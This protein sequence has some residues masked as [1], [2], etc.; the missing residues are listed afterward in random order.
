VCS[1]VALLVLWAI[2]AKV[3]VLVWSA[4]ATSSGGHC[5]LKHNSGLQGVFTRRISPCRRKGAV[6]VAQAAQ[7]SHSVWY[8]TNKKASWGY[9]NSGWRAIHRT[10]RDE[11]FIT[12]PTMSLERWDEKGLLKAGWCLEIVKTLKKYTKSYVQPLDL[13]RT[14]LVLSEWFN[15]IR[16]V[17]R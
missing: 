17:E 4:C 5:G 8:G 11:V 3:E 1:S 12:P 15:E 9:R 6:N 14:R 2:E 7:P 13:N 10:L 16:C